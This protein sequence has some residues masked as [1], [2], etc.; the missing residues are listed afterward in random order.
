MGCC[1][2]CIFF[3]FLKKFDPFPSSF[4]SLFPS[5][6]GFA[7]RRRHRRRESAL[8]VVTARL[9]LVLGDGDVPLGVPKAEEKGGEGAARRRLSQV[10]GLP[11]EKTEAGISALRHGAAPCPPGVCV[12][13]RD[14][15]PH[16]ITLL[17]LPCCPAWRPHSCTEF[18]S[19][20]CQG[21]PCAPWLLVPLHLR[22]EGNASQGMIPLG[23][24][25]GAAGLGTLW[26][27]PLP[28]SH[29][30]PPQP[31]VQVRPRLPHVWFPLATRQLGAAAS[32]NP[33]RP[34]H[35]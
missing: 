33:S 24:G 4:P 19:T 10:P 31:Q 29:C 32:L 1:F 26:G 13:P 23:D 8:S 20:L 2:V 16:T 18:V 27:G 28:P 3:S 22:G 34:R 14:S 35:T 9:G 25:W 11:G 7:C 15:C 12:S 30:L 17:I 21:H 6:V 5:G